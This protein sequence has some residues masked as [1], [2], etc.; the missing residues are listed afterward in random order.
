MGPRTHH[1]QGN[2]LSTSFQ[3]APTRE[4]PLAPAPLP[5]L[6]GV[7]VASLPASLLISEA[8]DN[9]WLRIFL[10]LGLMGACAVAL[11]KAGRQAAEQDPH[12]LW[13]DQR[14]PTEKSFLRVALIS[15]TLIAITVTAIVTA[16]PDSFG[17]PFPYMAAASFL[18]LVVPQLIARDVRRKY[19]RRQSSHHVP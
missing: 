1:A 18:Y 17:S 16:K 5:V 10:F 7:F 2:A 4:R 19:D 3:P 15:L 6:A 12:P 13:F 9:D 8:L 11:N 14:L